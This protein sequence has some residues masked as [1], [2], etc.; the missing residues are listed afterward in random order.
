MDLLLE[1]LL[2]SILEF[3][4]HIELIV[5][6]N[7]GDSQTKRVCDKYV[8]QGLPVVYSHEPRTGI[9]I[10]RNT[11]IFLSTGE[12]V[13]FLDDDLRLGNS[14]IRKI[15]DLIESSGADIICP[16]MIT[17]IQKDFPAWLTERLKSGIGQYDFR[18]KIV[19]LGNKVKIPIGACMCFRRSVF[20][21]C[22]PFREELGRK[23]KELLGG[24][25]TLF[26]WKAFQKGFK[27][28][29]VPDIEVI[30]VLSPFKESKRYWKRQGFGAGR[31]K[32]LMLKYQVGKHLFFPNLVFMAGYSATKALVR[33]GMM[34]FLPNSKFENY[35]KTLVHLGTVYQSAMCMV[36]VILRKS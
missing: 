11:A 17:P 8:E 3:I 28:I 9:S 34:L 1:D 13:L 35:Y 7:A 30:H 31:S 5:V 26:F 27:G 23:G 6:D 33:S 22:G 36:A 10:A 4:E 21:F 12:W 20:E 16:R 24:E 18:D 29:Y 14:F 32:V 25:E 2:K 15:L 19:E